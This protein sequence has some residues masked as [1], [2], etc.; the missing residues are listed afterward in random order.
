[1]SD[2]LTVIDL[3]DLIQNC[4]RYKNNPD[5][6]H[7]LANLIIEERKFE[8]SQ[9]IELEKKKRKAKVD[10]E[11]IAKMGVKDI[12]YIIENNV[13]IIVIMILLP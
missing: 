2:K 1:M 3:M 9:Q 6:V 12:V 8:E 10:L 11:E 4:D 7:E 5:F 13:E